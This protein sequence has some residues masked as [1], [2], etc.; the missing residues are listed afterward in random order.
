MRGAMPS[1]PNTLSWCGAQ[2]K[3]AQPDSYTVSITGS[4]P[5]GK[6]AGA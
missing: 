6:V 4:F 2:L 1:F 3:K 5:G